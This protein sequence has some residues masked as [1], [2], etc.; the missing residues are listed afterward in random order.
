[1]RSHMLATISIIFLRLSLPQTLHLSASLLG[2]TLLYHRS[3]CH[4]IIWGNGIPPKKIFL[5]TVF[6]A[7]AIDYTARI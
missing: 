3:P 2:A 4:D 1:M 5:G 6:P 7:F